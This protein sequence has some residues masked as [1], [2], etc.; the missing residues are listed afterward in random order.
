MKKFYQVYGSWIPAPSGGWFAVSQE[1]FASKQD[2]EIEIVR[3]GSQ[4]TIQL[5]SGIYPVS[6]MSFWVQTLSERD[7]TIWMEFT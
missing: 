4:D 2:A 1:R 7:G 6:E 5:G 3:I